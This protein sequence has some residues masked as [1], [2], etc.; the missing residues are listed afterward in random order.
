MKQHSYLWAFI[1]LITLFSSSYAQAESISIKATLIHGS[2][3]GDAI[4]PQLKAYEQNLKRIFK[5]SSY[6]LEGQGNTAIDLPSSGSIKLN[7][8]HSLKLDASKT[9]DG[10]IKLKVNWSEG[11][12][13]LINT[14]LVVRAGQPTIL[15]GPPLKGKPGNLILVIVPR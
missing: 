12:K 6:Q 1:I 15:G 8:S 7:S 9:E 11:N 3:E 13:G 5:Y 10:K 2:N 4:H 14:T